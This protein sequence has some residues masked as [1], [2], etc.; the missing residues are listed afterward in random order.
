MDAIIDAERWLVEN[1]VEIV[2][3]PVDRTAAD[4]QLGQS[5]CFRDPDGNLV[6]LLATEA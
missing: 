1:D 4:G 5:I 2:L 6:E 3:G